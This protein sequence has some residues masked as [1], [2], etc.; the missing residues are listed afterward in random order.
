M[1]YEC[2]NIASVCRT[3]KA[4]HLPWR[5]DVRI[6]PQ[7][8]EGNIPIIMNFYVFTLSK[9]RF[10][11]VSCATLLLWV[12]TNYSRKQCCVIVVLFHRE[13]RYLWNISHLSPLPHL[14]PGAVLRLWQTVSL[15]PWESQPPSNSCHVINFIQKQEQWKVRISSSWQNVLCLTRV[16]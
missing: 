11:S 14:P 15:L 12:G 7:L 2:A 3:R 16:Q 9:S 5:P 6:E 13:L 4:V 8:L 1:T 10:N